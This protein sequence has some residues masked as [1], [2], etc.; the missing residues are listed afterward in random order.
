MPRG[1]GTVY[2]GYCSE[3]NARITTVRILKRNKANFRELEK[4]CPT[5]RKRMPVKLKE[6][7]H[8]S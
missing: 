1:K 8:S 7:K 6:E 3:C 2:A 4:F 5:E